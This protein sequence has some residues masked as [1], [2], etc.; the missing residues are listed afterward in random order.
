MRAAT[1]PTFGQE[2]FSVTDGRGDEAKIRTGSFSATDARDGEERND[3]SSDDEAC[4]CPE[5]WGKAPEV[6]F[7]YPPGPGGTLTCP[8][9]LGILPK[10][11]PQHFRIASDAGDTETASQ[12]CEARPGDTKHQLDFPDVPKLIWGG[13][14]SRVISKKWAA[15]E[16]Q[17]IL[18]ARAAI[19]TPKRLCR[20]RGNFSQHH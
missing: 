15:S 6:G 11:E 8:D 14:W 17:C 10:P 5:W 19:F 16:P 13:C 1:K 18:E 20:C 12:E 7:H 3:S 4:N 9:C 2:V